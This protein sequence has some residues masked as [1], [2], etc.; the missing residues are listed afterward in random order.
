MSR[1]FDRNREAKGLSALTDAML[2]LAS[3]EWTTGHMTKAQK[4]ERF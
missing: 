2:A 3:G 1:Y 4:A